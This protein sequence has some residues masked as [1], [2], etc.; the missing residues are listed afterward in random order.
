MLVQ[1]EGRPYAD[2]EPDRA[3]DY[4][5]DR[6][7]VSATTIEAAVRILV[8]ACTFSGVGVTERAHHLVANVTG[9]CP[10]EYRQPVLTGQRPGLLSDESSTVRSKDSRR[11]NPPRSVRFRCATSRM[12][13]S[14]AP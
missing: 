7:V 4:G 9:D 1:Q 13:S 3:G 14:V 6:G 2:D 12:L 5:V 8:A 11:S 10:S